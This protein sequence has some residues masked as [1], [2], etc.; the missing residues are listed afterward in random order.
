MCALTAT[1]STAVD[2]YKFNL[3]AHTARAS[4]RSECKFVELI[5]MQ[6]TPHSVRTEDIL[7]FERTAGVFT[8]YV[9]EA[10]AAESK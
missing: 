1:L 10:S 2:G 9:E 8:Y 7:F 6:S 5:S 3:S 4:I